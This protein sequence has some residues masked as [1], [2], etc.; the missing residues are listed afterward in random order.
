MQE[1]T[2]L[3]GKETVATETVGLGTMGCMAVARVK[4]GCHG[5]TGDAVLKK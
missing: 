4:N 2:K 5:K 3:V 1:K